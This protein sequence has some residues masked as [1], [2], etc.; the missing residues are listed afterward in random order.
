MIDFDL[1]VRVIRSET[2]KRD[3]PTIIE[4]LMGVSLVLM[5]IK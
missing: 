5:N 1:T 3:F 4:I 2:K